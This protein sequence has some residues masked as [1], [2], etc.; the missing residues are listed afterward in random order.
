MAASRAARPAS[1]APSAPLPFPRRQAHRL[2]R[3]RETASPSAPTTSRISSSSSIGGGTPRN[4]TAEVRLRHRRRDRRRPAR[5]ARR[6]PAAPSGADG[7]RPRLR[8]G[9]RTGQRRPASR[10]RRQ[11]RVDRT[12]ARRRTSCPTPPTPRAE[13]RDGDLHADGARRSLRRDGGT[14]KPPKK[15]T[16]FNDALFGELT[17]NEPEEIWYPSFDGRKIQGWILKP[18]AS[19]REEVPAHPADPRRAARRLRQHLHPRV[20]VDGGQGLRRPLHEPARQ[21]E[22]RAGVRQH[23]PVQLSRRRLQGPDGGRRRG[24]EEGLHRRE[25]LGVTGGSGGGLLTNWVVTQTTRFKAA[26][27]QRDISDWSN[28][29]YTPTSRCS[30]RRGS[31]RR[32][33]RIRR[34]S[35]SARRSPTSRRSRRR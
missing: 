24:A 10:R 33:S 3:Q 30:R 26:V 22:L 27:S 11:R 18:P 32:R 14:G 8:Q 12:V 35:R 29:W 20:P 21:L 9:R 1:T 23:H 16:S 6:H 31:A 28:F 7:R 2:H 15:L 13:L 4:L 34:S 25:A 5:A 19:T 17:M